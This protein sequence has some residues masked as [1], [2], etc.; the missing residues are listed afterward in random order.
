VRGGPA[1][2]KPRRGRDVIVTPWPSPAVRHRLPT[3]LCC[4]VIPSPRLS[5]DHSITLLLEVGS[6]SE[7]R[8]SLNPSPPSDEA[9][10]TPSALALRWLPALRSAL[11]KLSAD[12]CLA[13][14]LFSC[15]FESL[16]SGLVSET[17]W[18]L[19]VTLST[20]SPRRLRWLPASR[21]AL[22][23]RWLPAS[24]SALRKI[25]RPCRADAR[26]S[27][28]SSHLSRVLMLRCRRQ[29]TTEIEPIKALSPS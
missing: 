10:A 20:P 21:S 7:R 29:R 5:F 13:D 24:R 2:P 6:P 14:A 15:S 26:S 16:E 28:S 17:A 18:V 19:R 9:R 3:T 12:P 4:V 22:R 11:P 27:C 25:G 23:L 1:G 8:F